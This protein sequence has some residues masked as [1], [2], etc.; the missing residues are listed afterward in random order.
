MY[1]APL[2]AGLFN[3]VNMANHHELSEIITKL[4]HILTEV[5]EIRYDL[6]KRKVE[7]RLIA[8]FY[9]IF[10]LIGLSI[11]IFINPETSNKDVLNKELEEAPAIIGTLAISSDD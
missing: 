8:I 3:E 7:I 10:I 4:N 5:K 6:V 2:K 1:V 9:F 11:A